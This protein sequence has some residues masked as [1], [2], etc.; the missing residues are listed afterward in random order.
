MTDRAS[1]HF[2]WLFKILFIG[3]SAVG[4]S[5]IL[6][7]FCD[8]IFKTNFNSTFGIDFKIK[9][10]ELKGKII[11]LQIWDTA[12][13]ERFHSITTAYYRGAMGIMLVY[14]ITNPK[15][16]NNLGKWLTNLQEHANPDAIKMILANKCDLEDKRIIAAQR[17]QEIAN[18]H[19]LKFLETSANT[20]VN[21]EKAFMDLT[22]DILEMQPEYIEPTLLSEADVE[23]KQAGSCNFC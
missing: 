4:K 17:G 8:D 9:S 6:Y 22:Q 15:S 3:D 19:G 20:N 10:V 13:T 12:G 2:D 11:K 1:H 5:S 16:F 14:D 18:Q 7:R 23:K 21:I